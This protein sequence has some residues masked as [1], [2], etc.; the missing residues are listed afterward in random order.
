MNYRFTFL[1]HGES[2]GN[3]D[4]Y[5]QGQHDFPLSTKG[6]EQ[7]NL[8][9]R[10]WH[11]QGIHF[12]RIITSP[13]TR[14]LSTAE[15]IH[16]ILG[17]PI[18]EDRIWMERYWGNHQGNT[19]EELDQKYLRPKFVQL[20][21][22]LGGDG[23]SEWQLFLR[24]GV[25]LQTLFSNP[26]GEYLIV[27]HGGL[28]DKILHTIFGIKPQANFQGL[29]FEFRN[30]TYTQ[31]EYHTERNQW[32]MLNFI[33][34]EDPIKSHQENFKR[35]DFTFVRHAESTGNVE[36]V[37]QGQSETPLSKLG[38]EQA[39][40]F[41]SLLAQKNRKFDYVLSS[42]QLRAKQTAELICQPLKLPI[43]T[44]SLL[45][46]ID[47]GL[48]AGLNGQEID[49]SFP[50]RPDRT[51]PYLPVGKNGE[52]WLELYLRGMRIVDHLISHPPGEYLII[53]HG[54]ILNAVIWSILGIP[55]Q[56]SRRS[57]F[58]I[59]ENTGHCELSFAPEENR[60]RFLSLN[61]ATISTQTE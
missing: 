7:T 29:L 20:F 48:L 30:T 35:Y 14:A 32:R 15:I 39:L 57:S 46:E 4:G 17:T 50:E 3:R 44:F 40:S 26:P 28:L 9:A 43:N 16:S 8:L 1:R 61:P 36:K 60:W 24:A 34:P 38:E 41:G 18:H 58:F 23:E 45:K 19:L 37:F 27:S 6:I 49:A 10:R 33:Q 53:S 25:A 31:V 52:S 47:N 2:V 5:V 42:P 59:F 54:T 51:N 21:D 12:D 56:P 22:S 13:L 11:D 55:P